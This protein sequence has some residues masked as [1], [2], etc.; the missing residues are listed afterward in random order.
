M[1]RPVLKHPICR[2][3]TI[4]MKNLSRLS[5]AA[6]FAALALNCATYAQTPSVTV[7]PSAITNDYVGKIVLTISNVA[8]GQKVFVQRYADFNGNGSVDAQDWLV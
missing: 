6:G 5:T 2:V 4:T 1:A 7:S 3:L 8:P